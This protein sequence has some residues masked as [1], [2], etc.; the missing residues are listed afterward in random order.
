MCL[1]GSQ[2]DHNCVIQRAGCFFNVLGCATSEHESHGL[3]IVALSEHIVAF[4]TQLH[5]LKLSASS[6]HVSRQAVRCRL[7]HGPSRL[8]HSFQVF[9]ADAA[10]TENVSV[11]E[12]LSR[13]VTDWQLRE[14][15]FGIRSDNLIK[16]VI[17]DCTS[18]PKVFKVV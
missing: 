16:F 4:V 1:N 8:A 18:V 12:I 7:H 17:N 13:Q 6:Q 11:S 14:D 2:H 10:S 3:G 9:L 15:D 5:F